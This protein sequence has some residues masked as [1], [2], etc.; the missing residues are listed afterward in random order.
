MRV[1]TIQKVLEIIKHQVIYPDGDQILDQ[2][3]REYGA[4]TVKAALYEWTANP[5][6]C[7]RMAE[8]LVD[9]VPRLWHRIENEPQRR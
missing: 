7:I 5:E 4:E 9:V 6:G 3:I 8:L 1:A 2:L